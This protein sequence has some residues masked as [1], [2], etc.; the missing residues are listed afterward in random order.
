MALNFIEKRVTGAEPTPGQPAEGR[1]PTARLHRHSRPRR[2]PDLPALAERSWRLPLALAAGIFAV[3]GPAH[4]LGH[5]DVVYYLVLG[6]LALGAVALT[7]GC[8][9]YATTGWPSSPRRNTRLF[10]S[11]SPGSQ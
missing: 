8:W 11:A 3:S 5:T 4:A 6:A 10:R 7:A 2:R 1:E 9:D